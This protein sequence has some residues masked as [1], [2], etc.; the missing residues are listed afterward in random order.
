MSSASIINHL[1]NIHKL[2]NKSTPNVVVDSKLITKYQLGLTKVDKE[3]NTFQIAEIIRLLLSIISLPNFSNCENYDSLIDLLPSILL[4]MKFLEIVSLVS[5]P[6]FTEITGEQSFFGIFKSCVYSP[7]SEVQKIPFEILSK[8]TQL[9]DLMNLD[10]R[11]V[12]LIFTCYIDINMPLSVVNAIDNLFEYLL[13]FSEKKD[14]MERYFSD[15]YFNFLNDHCYIEDQLNLTLQLR[16]LDLLIKLVR[17]GNVCLKTFKHILHFLESSDLDIDYW[18]YMNKQLEFLNLVVKN[19]SEDEGLDIFQNDIKLLSKC[20]LTLRDN[21]DFQSLCASEFFIF[22]HNISFRHYDFFVKNKVLPIEL[23]KNLYDPITMRL[24]ACVNPKYLYSF[25]ILDTSYFSNLQISNKIYFEIL[26]NLIQENHIF[27][28][29]TN[30]KVLTIKTIKNNLTWKNVILLIGVLSN[31]QLNYLINSFSMLVHEYLLDDNLDISDLE[32]IAIS[33]NF[34]NNQLRL[35][36]IE[37]ILKNL[38]DHP[39]IKTEITNDLICQ[40]QK[41]SNGDIYS[42]TEFRGTTQGLIETKYQ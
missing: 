26:C 42:P 31:F 5:N 9:E 6:S 18:L 36:V 35:Q 2:L 40:K 20:F 14:I 38:K 30:E 39:E 22:F 17:S 15:N 25:Q 32:A 27:S 16:V 11:I 12:S 19:S 33:T 13:S 7:F 23:F 34:K 37:E 28:E 1:S 8:T 41:L 29:L 21:P 4:K 3:E 24:L 10:N